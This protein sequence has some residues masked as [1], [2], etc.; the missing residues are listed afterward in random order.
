MVQNYRGFKNLDGIDAYNIL[1]KS[2]ITTYKR[3]INA[4]PNSSSLAHKLPKVASTNKVRKVA[5]EDLELG[6]KSV[7]KSILRKIVRINVSLV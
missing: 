6:S 4:R 2:F 7:L 1:V 3:M 5:D